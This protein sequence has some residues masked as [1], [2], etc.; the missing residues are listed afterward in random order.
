MQ[1]DHPALVAR[2]VVRRQT[3]RSAT[4]PTKPITSC[5]R[6]GDVRTAIPVEVAERQPNAGS[7]TPNRLATDYQ[8]I[9]DEAGRAV[10]SG[11]CRAVNFR[12]T[13]MPPESVIKTQSPE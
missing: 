4:R 2:D 9:A 13:E 8:E 10:L 3:P 11:H 12:Q 7:M 6:Q 5:F 1:D